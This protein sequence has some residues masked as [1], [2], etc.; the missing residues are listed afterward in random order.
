MRVIAVLNQKG[1]VG[2]TTT[3]VNVSAAMARTGQR[4]LLI[5]LDPQA[6]ATIHLGVEVGP[7]E[8]CIYDV[9]TRGAPVPD[10]ARTVADGFFIVPSHIDLVGAEI[11]LANRPD[12]ERVLAH[13]LA[14]CDDRFDI[15]L[16]DCAPALGLLAINA[17]AAAREIIIPLQP[18]FLA[19]Q[20]LGRLLET[21]TLVRRAL[22]PQL[23]V[24]GVVLC[25]Y[26]RG[27]KLAQEVHDDVAGFLARAS[28]S[29]PWFGARVF[30]TSIRRNIRLAEC[31][32]FGK[33]VFDY[34]PGSHGAE[35]Y[36]ALAEEILQVGILPADQTVELPAPVA[37]STPA[38]NPS[39]GVTPA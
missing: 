14:V 28:P 24:L 20:G 29:D 35:D 33:T 15:C 11:E 18:H 5:D 38:D 10:V 9:L 37:A 25:M 36:A 21:V 2:K 3:A 1:G 13:A 32:S 26:E 7:Q 4:V 6:H 31:P 12:R 8:L 34:A 23:R 19:L 16:I 30:A 27:T 22:N 39:A 17:L